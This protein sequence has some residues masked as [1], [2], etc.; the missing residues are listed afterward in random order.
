MDTAAPANGLV[1][2]QWAMSPRQMQSSTL[3]D[4]CVASWD[5][6]LVFDHLHSNHQAFPADVA[7]DL[8]FVPE[9]CQ[10]CHEMGADVEAVLLQA[11]LFD[12][13]RRRRQLSIQCA[14]NCVFIAPLPDSTARIT[15]LINRRISP[16]IQHRRSDS[17]GHRV[18]SEGVEMNGLVKRGCDF[19][20]T[21][22]N[23]DHTSLCCWASR[24]GQRMLFWL[25]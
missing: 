4:A 9:F 23:G 11:V 20:K 2:Q 17:T 7:D 1:V 21:R 24:E 22:G 25:A 5:S 18:S 12:S 19:C 8:V 6:H 14:A 10:F 3:L 13:L 15:E 16:H